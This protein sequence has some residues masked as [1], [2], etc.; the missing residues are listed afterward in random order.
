MEKGEIPA[1]AI[2][3]SQARQ[4]ANLGDEKLSARL[5]ELWGAVRETPAEKKKELEKWKS[6]LTKEAVASADPVRGKQFFAQ[7]CGACHVLYGE[8]GK[9]GPDL[10]G[11]DRHNV[12]YI[13]ESTINPSDV[14]PA[15]Y[16]LTVFTLRDG[17]GRFRSHCGQRL[18][19]QLRFNQ[20]PVR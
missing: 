11:S 18:T 4:I 5:V 6:L 12:D 16:R 17:R 3:P 1:N 9:I 20:P 8:G 19:K 2:S 7:S 10:T 14:I 15:D 13:L